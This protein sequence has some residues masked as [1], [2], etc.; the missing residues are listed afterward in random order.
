MT[1]EELLDLW[2]E[3][4]EP[5]FVKWLDKNMDKVDTVDEE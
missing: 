1:N 2:R 5:N 3:S 4:G